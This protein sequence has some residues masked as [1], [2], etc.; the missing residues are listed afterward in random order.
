MK[1]ST[2]IYPDFTVIIP[3]LNEEKTIGLLLTKIELIIPDAS[4]IVADDGSRDKTKIIVE[5]FTGNLQVRFL[6]RQN[7]EVH[8]YER[9]TLFCPL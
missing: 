4:I 2:E 3:T 5:G 8:G 1:P 6:D 7:E 9:K